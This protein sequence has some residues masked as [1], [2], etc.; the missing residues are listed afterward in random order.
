[1]QE[2]VMEKRIAYIACGVYAIYAIDEENKTVTIE[3]LVCS[4]VKTLEDLRF[5]NEKIREKFNELFLTENDET[6]ELSKDLV[7]AYCKRL[8]MTFCYYSL[9][10]VKLPDGNVADR[11]I[12]Q[13]LAGTVIL[14]RLY[15]TGERTGIFADKITSESDNILN[16][17]NSE[18]GDA[19]RGKYDVFYVDDKPSNKLWEAQHGKGEYEYVHCFTD[20]NGNL[21]EATRIE[22]NLDDETS[23]KMVQFATAALDTTGDSNEIHSHMAQIIRHALPNDVESGAY[24]SMIDKKENRS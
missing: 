10:E 2:A 11:L 20:E 16:I 5:K 4:F 17:I 8:D 14:P 7:E 21:H 24:Y 19:E 1:V 23:A 12:F 13:S 22:L 6:V 18:M 3:E 15:A 9:E